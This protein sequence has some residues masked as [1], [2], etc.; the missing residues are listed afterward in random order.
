MEF[1]VLET[2]RLILRQL[3]LSDSQDVFEYFSQ[4]QVMKYYDLEAFKSLEDARNII[5][6]FNTEFEN[7]KGFRWALELKSEKKVIGTCGYHNWYREH[8]RAEIGYELN[9]L[10]WKQSFMKE[11]ILPIL[12]FGFESMQLHRVDAF[13]DPDNISSEKLLTSLNFQEEGTM[14]DYFFEKGKFVDAR[15]FGLIN[16]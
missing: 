8:F 11:A 4:D 12:T 9:P 14:K 1:P 3:T 5:E 6:H 16:K 13:I 7:G 2:E 10:F 15:L